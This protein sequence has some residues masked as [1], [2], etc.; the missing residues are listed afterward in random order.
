MKYIVLMVLAFLQVVLAVLLGYK[1]HSK[2]S[3]VFILFA[4]NMAV[5][6]VA[7]ILLDY[8]QYQVKDQ[9]TFID[10]MNRV[11]F[12]LGTLSLITVYRLSLV[13]PVEKAKTKAQGVITAVGLVVPFLTL[14]PLVS[15]SFSQSAPGEVA[16]YTYGPLVGV[17]GLYVLAIAALSIKNMFSAF[18]SVEPVVRRQAY[19]VFAGLISSI[20]LGAFFITVLPAVIG[21]ERF[22][23]L[24]YA[25]PL[26][27]TAS[28]FYSIFRQQLLNFRA[29]VARSAAYI[30]LVAVF[31]ATY[32]ILVFGISNQ[33]L[34]TPDFN[35]IQQTFYILAAL[36]LAF[37]YQP[38]KKFID[39][40]TNKLFYRDAYDAQ[41]LLNDLNSELVSSI[42][43]KNILKNT[44]LLLEHYLKPAEVTFVVYESENT[45]ENMFTTSNSANSRTNDIIQAA[46][47]VK[48]K[49]FGLEDNAETNAILKK[50]KIESDIGMV[51][52][53]ISTGEKGSL[54][55]SLVLGPKKSGNPYAQQD[56]KVL[57]IIA[58]EL[59]IAIQ[60][61]LRFEEIQQ[62]NVTLQA[63]VDKATGELRKAN[64]KLVAMD[65][66]KDDFISMASHQLRTPLTS[67]KGY[68][69]MVLEGDVGKITKEQRKLLDQAFLSSQ[70]M[71]YL[72][73]D[74]LNV[75]RLKTGKFIIESAPT[76]LADVV[77]GE[78][79]QLKE[80]AEAR[81][82]EV[83]YDKPK[84]FPVL[85]M[86]ETKIRQVVMNFADNAIYYTP[87]G[88]HVVVAVVDKGE[89][90][91]FTVTD[92][93][94]GVPKAEQHQLFNKFY[95]AGNAKKARPDGT[96]LG[97]FMAK[98]VV[99]AQGGSIIFKTAE[100]KGSTFG[101]SFEK[102]KLEAGT[103]TVNFADTS[104]ES[105]EVTEVQKANKA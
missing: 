46:K 101:F 56:Q 49:I 8:Y 79:E 53:L 97:L 13:F 17:V 10:I 15:G 71:V 50:F 5:W 28:V 20:I 84:N 82:L 22:L 31:A 32:A 48:E 9:L 73:A 52:Q 90:I 25:A 34:G 100:G 42:E 16:V 104:E 40:F 93:G 103:H 54:V 18:K 80:T 96:G 43:V 61:A 2:V 67:V 89:T 1:K 72:I 27:F 81:K 58:D 68:V 65:Q 83:K 11:G 86:D 24:G 21:S 26:L 30:I 74:L 55:G 33:V 75:S 39:R 57:E 87:A 102:K 91:E 76:N 38:I 29:I 69:S 70:R 62:F 7:N 19:T 63:K 35:L 78:L 92:D 59:V 6:T 36:F 4:A 44:S 60:N 94:I 37:S 64:E 3:K 23:F 51:A 66:T 45:P 99:I 95:R 41:S 98:K 12:F 85:N 14:S 77:E 47:E 105:E 88:G